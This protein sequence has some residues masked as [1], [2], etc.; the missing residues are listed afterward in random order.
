MSVVCT[1]AASPRAQALEARGSLGSFGHQTWQ[2]ENGLPQNSV[3]AIAQSADGYLWLG[4][5]GGLAR[6]DGYSFT[7]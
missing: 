1:L 5:D 4:T 2:T 3:H 7:V 6:F